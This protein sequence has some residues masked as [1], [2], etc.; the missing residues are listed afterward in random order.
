MVDLARFPL[1]QAVLFD[2]S[3]WMRS[4]NWRATG[5]FEYL[6]D[7]CGGGI[8]VRSQCLDPSRHLRDTFARYRGNIRFSGTLS[9][10]RLYNQLHGLDEAPCERAASA[11]DER[12]LAVLL[13]RDINTYLR[14]REASISRLVEAIHSVF[15]RLSRPLFGGFSVLRLSGLLCRRGAIPVSRDQSASSNAGYDG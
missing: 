8:S 6:L 11:F 13:V 7:T 12:Q 4:E 10:L 2:A 15:F 3:R 14:E 5:A 9:P 1:L